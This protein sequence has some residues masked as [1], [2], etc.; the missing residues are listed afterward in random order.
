MLLV[1]QVECALSHSHHPQSAPSQVFRDKRWQTD[2]QDCLVSDDSWDEEED[3]EFS[4][5]DGSGESDGEIEDVPG[6]CRRKRQTRK[7][8][9][10]LQLSDQL[11]LLSPT[12]KSPVEA[13]F[14]GDGAPATVD[15]VSSL[16]AKVDKKKKKKNR[17]DGI[18]SD[19]E[20]PRTGSDPTPTASQSKLT[21]RG[22]SN[23]MTSDYGGREVDE[24]VKEKNSPALASS[25]PPWIQMVNTCRLCVS[26]CFHQDKAD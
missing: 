9:G 17:S 24:T 23:S 22:S 6:R 11:S 8:V 10:S 15:D 20:R 7:F 3:S 16:Y 12:S 19:Q 25:Q 1:G 4:N 26:F 2:K 21:S 14:E 13:S 5:K 18:E